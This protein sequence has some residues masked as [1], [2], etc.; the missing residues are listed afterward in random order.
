[1]ATIESRLFALEHR[2]QACIPIFRVQL[3][4]GSTMTVHGFELVTLTDV[5]TVRYDPRQECAGEVIGLFAAL[6]PGVEVITDGVS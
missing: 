2:P 5:E 1:M 4:D 6:N 3:A